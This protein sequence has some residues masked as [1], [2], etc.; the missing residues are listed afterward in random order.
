MWL[1]PRDPAHIVLGPADNVDRNG[2]IEE[3]HD[4]GRSWQPASSGL[5]VPWPR[6]MVERFKQ[7]GDELFAVLSN[8]EL[9]VAPLA[10]L[11]WRRVLEDARGVTAISDLG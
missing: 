9:Y 8:G 2:R 4:G 6:H 1:D 7:I 10:E 3:T 5:T 11:N